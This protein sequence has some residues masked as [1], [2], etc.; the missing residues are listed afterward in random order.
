MD[1]LGIANIKQIYVKIVLDYKWIEKC[2][3]RNGTTRRYDD[4]SGSRI[5]LQ[6]STL[7]IKEPNIIIISQNKITVCKK[8]INYKNPI[9]EQS[10]GGYNLATD[11]RFAEHIHANVEPPQS[12]DQNKKLLLNPCVYFFQVILFTTLVTQQLKI[13]LILLLISMDL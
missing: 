5:F 12:T 9:S 8:N 11:W 1:F 10:H 13:T 2:T 3:K 4:I 6:V 7:H